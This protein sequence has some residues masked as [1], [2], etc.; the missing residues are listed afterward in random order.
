[1]CSFVYLTLALKTIKK[2][3]SN[4]MTKHILIILM[5]TLLI[6]E[7]KAHGTNTMRQS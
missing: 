4:K 6:L 7:L 2:K 3:K 5:F 1:M